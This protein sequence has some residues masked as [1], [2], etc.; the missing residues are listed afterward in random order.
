[1]SNR[2]QYVS[3]PSA[4]SGYCTVSCGVPQGS[5]LGPLLF[6]L[7]NN[8][9]TF[10][11][12]L[13]KFHLFADDSNL[14]YSNKSL[15][16]LEKKVNDELLLIADWLSANKLSLNVKKS[17]VL[18]HPPQKK[19][20]SNITLAI[21]NN[22]LTKESNVKYLGVYI[23]SHLNWK[24]HISLTSKKISRNIGILTKVRHFVSQ[25][26]LTSLYYAFVYPFLIYGLIIGITLTPPLLLPLL[27][28]KRKLCALIF[29]NFDSLSSQLFKEHMTR[30]QF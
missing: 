18:F 23:D 3:L 8:D 29:A 6:L 7:Y 4:S 28:Y 26:V 27:T 30:N 19:V 20:S 5:V 11:S 14:F 17:H 24:K 13:L 15:S 2:R 25:K 9:I 22:Q 16:T 12:T 10:C 1:M 21:G